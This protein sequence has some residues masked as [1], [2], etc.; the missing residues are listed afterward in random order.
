[1]VILDCD[2]GNTRCK[3]RMLS[4][5][6]VVASGQFSHRDGFGDLVLVPAPERVR[7]ASVASDH[8][9]AA[10]M[11]RLQDVGVEPEFAVSRA[12]ECGVVNGYD[13]PEKLGVDRW[14]AIVAAFRRKQK[15]VLIVDAGSALT[16][17]AV[18]VDGAHMGG[19][20][21]PGAAYMRDSLLSNTGGVEFN[22]KAKAFG[23]D[24]GRTT[25]AAVDA[26]VLSAQVG[27]V[28]VAVDTAK[29]QLGND[30]ELVLTGGDAESI[31]A[32]LPNNIN[33]EVEVVAELVLDGLGWVLP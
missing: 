24:W 11:A 9:L 4:G 2:V 26:G 27:V 22:P 15:A 29:E 21:L 7:V 30:F 20:I 19:Y 8:V 6:A 33:V 10:L 14:L 23:L 32:H 13:V 31:R 12:E 17:D 25:Q 1:M 28:L 16:V 3:W 5:S 18:N